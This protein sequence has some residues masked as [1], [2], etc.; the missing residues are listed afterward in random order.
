MY[1]DIYRTI[2]RGRFLDAELEQDYLNANRTEYKL[3]SLAASRY[4]FCLS[5]LA[6]V[7]VAFLRLKLNFFSDLILSLGTLTA[8]ALT[9]FS[10]LVHRQVR[11]E[12]FKIASVFQAFFGLKLMMTLIFGFFLWYSTFESMQVYAITANLSLF[13]FYFFFPDHFLNK[14]TASLIFSLVYFEMS[15]MMFPA[16]WVYHLGALLLLGAVNYVGAT[17]VLRLDTS[18]RQSFLLQQKLE[19]EI[20]EHVKTRFELE[21]QVMMDPLTEVYNRRFFEEK[22]R[23]SYYNAERYGHVFSLV[24]MD[25]DYFKRINDRHGHHV[26]DRVLQWFCA[27]IK[28]ELRDTDVLSRYGGEEFVLILPETQLATAL[29]VT[30]RIQERLRVFPFLHEGENLNVTCSM[31]ISTYHKSLSAT[32]ILTRADDALYESKAR[33]RNQVNTIPV[34]GVS[35]AV[36]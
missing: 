13:A 12:N 7:A 16:H 22:Y 4:L 11:L 27:Q 28:K 33:G 10:V 18:N 5:A 17:S 29:V 21:Y 20:E 14:L 2:Y 9:G 6:L 32:D 3:K 1:V 19:R 15:L 34:E 36:Y 25:L 30:E 31:G 23:E 8:V 35:E 26:G 24:M